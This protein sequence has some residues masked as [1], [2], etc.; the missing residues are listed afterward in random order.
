MKKVYLLL[1]NNQQ[2]GPFT[3][4][5]LVKQGLKPTD[6][7]WEEGR[8]HAWCYPSELPEFKTV[9]DPAIQ[10]PPVVPTS[11]S[12]P[13]EIEKRAE[14]LRQKVLSFA[15]SYYSPTEWNREKVYVDAYNAYQSEKIELND[16]RK[17][18][19]PLYEWMSGVAVMLIVVIGVYGGQKYFFSRS[20]VVSEGTTRTV[21]TDDHAAKVT[22]RVL[23]ATPV[24]VQETLPDS[25]SL[26]VPVAEQRLALRPSKRKTAAPD[27]RPATTIEKRTRKEPDASD[28][29]SSVTDTP[30]LQEPVKAEAIEPVAIVAIGPVEK[31]KSGGLFK[32]LFKKKKKPGPEE[33]KTEE[34]GS[35]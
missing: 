29:T 14:E 4:D 11:P 26:A 28:S 15:P 17:R 23:P 16:H 12:A 27:V 18:E 21:T 19:V 34:V 31:K 5:E 9:A 24:L 33:T 25:S 35:N 22:R 13:D 32:G 20:T 3:F 2:R 8:S 7:V 6:L 1:R 30:P 10:K